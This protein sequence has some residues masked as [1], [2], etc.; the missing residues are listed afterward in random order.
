MRKLLRNPVQ[1]P[2]GFELE[3]RNK[4][5]SVNQ[6]SV[7]GPVLRVETTLVG[8]LTEHLD[9]CLYRRIYTESNKTPGGLHVEAEAQ[10]FQKAVSPGCRIHA[11]TLTQETQISRKLAHGGDPVPTSA[12]GKLNQSP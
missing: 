5:R 3:D 12:S 2:T 10:R 4:I 8:P 7:F 11:F 9:P 1:M 6:R